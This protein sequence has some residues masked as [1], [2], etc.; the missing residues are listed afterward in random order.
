MALLST[1][2]DILTTNPPSA[3]HGVAPA[4]AMVSWMQPEIRDGNN[5][6]SWKELR[7]AL[8]RNDEMLKSLNQMTN[9]SIFD[10]HLQYAERFEMR[11]TNLI[12]EK[13]AAQRLSASAIS[14]LHFDDAASAAKNIQAMLVLVNGT[15]EERTDR[16]DRGAA[17][18]MR[19]TT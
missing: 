5:T 12:S 2:D 14:D 11:I 7:A 10:F 18:L 3:M 15:G 4:K 9:N 17:R 1:N 8:A 6:N 16:R 19:M 13:R